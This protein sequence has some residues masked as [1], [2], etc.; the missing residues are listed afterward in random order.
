ML[1]NTNHGYKLPVEFV[2]T[3]N[4]PGG[5]LEEQVHQIYNLNKSVNVNNMRFVSYMIVIVIIVLCIRYY[6]K[7]NMKHLE[8]DWSNQKCNPRFLF[9]SGFLQKDEE[10][11]QYT[12]DNFVT[13][14]KP[15]ITALGDA[16]KYVN[17]TAAYMNTAVDSITAV[18]K[19]IVNTNKLIVDKWNARLSTKRT[20]VNDMQDSMDLIYTQ[21]KK[22]YN[23]ISLYMERLFV[24]IDYMTRYTKDMLLIKAKQSKTKLNFDNNYNAIVQSYKNICN[25]YY[26]QAFSQLQT[27][28]NQSGYDPKYTEFS[29]CV[30]TAQAA[31]QQFNAISNTIDAYYVNHPPS[32][33]AIMD[34]NCKNL[35]T[36]FNN[37]CVKENIFPYWTS[38]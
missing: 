35:K 36:S 3:P 12:Y 13:C 30:T 34:D 5:A 10:P 4:R 11:L 28:R 9:F 24:I 33:V 1:N 2:L 29:Q 18:Y 26:T 21:Q 7:I 6:F 32:D 25:S 15:H 17:N 31:M 20:D 8:L 23:V 19:D 27:T 38:P 22:L 16:F 37:E 14:S